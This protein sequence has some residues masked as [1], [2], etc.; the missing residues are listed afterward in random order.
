[1]KRSYGARRGFVKAR[2]VGRYLPPVSRF[3]AL[4]PGLALVLGSPRTASAQGLPAFAPVNPVAT[5]RSGLSFLPYQEARQGWSLNLALDY[6][7]TIEDNSRPPADY[8]LDSELLRLRIAL[9]RDLGPRTFLLIEPQ[10]RG[11][12]P[13]FLDGF[14][15]WYHRLLGI[16][17]PERDRRPEDSFRYSVGL[18]DG[19]VFARRPDDLFLG[20][21]RAGVGV[22]LL[23]AL[24]SAML[25]TLPTSTGPQ[26]YGTGVVSLNLLNTVRATL[27]PGLQY[28]GSLS[29][30]Y[31]P[32]H[33]AMTDLQRTVFLAASS[34]LRFRFWGRQSVY[35]N[36]FYHSPYYHG[37]N[38][39]G[40][41]RR[42]L[43]LDFGWILAAKSGREWR[44]GLTEDVEPGGPSVD[45]V[46]RL[47]AGF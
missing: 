35:A 22:R 31:T 21:L 3:L 30:G 14:L 34:G 11:A 9:R 41:D 4:L 45:L 2:A 39:P 17:V 32:A 47:G 12:Y 7:S 18:P 15:D 29:A 6:A 44:V 8:L 33:G 27:H 28:E 38:L 23:P 25:L 1:M 40:L 46:F 36:L 20:D 26:G 19:R 10:V 43:S 13:G 16:D 42:D 37:T 24:Q 5:S